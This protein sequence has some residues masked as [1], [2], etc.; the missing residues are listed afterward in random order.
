MA[1]APIVAPVRS[2]VPTMARSSAM[3][4]IWGLC[5]NPNN[6]AFGMS[7]TYASMIGSARPRVPPALLMAAATSGSSVASAAVMI[8][9]D[10]PTAIAARR[11]ASGPIFEPGSAKDEAAVAKIPSS[12]AEM[13][14]D[15]VHRMA[16]S[17]LTNRM[18]ERTVATLATQ[19]QYKWVVVG[20]QFQLSG[21]KMVAHIPSEP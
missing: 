18:A 1:V 9:R 11:E 21:S 16:P 17:I 10:E 5:D 8:T 15:A 20:A 19:S 12:A 3:C 4:E 6:A 7:A 14:N 13:F 2:I